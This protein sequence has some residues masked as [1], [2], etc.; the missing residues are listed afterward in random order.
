MRMPDLR[1]ATLL[2]LTNLLWGA[3]PPPSNW[4]P[5][6]W[7]WADAQSLELLEGSPVNCVLLKAYNPDL[8]GAA[9]K[10]GLVVLAVVP[11][12]ADPA[13]AVRR[14]LA[15]GVTGI[16]ME[17]NFSESVIAS[18]RR[19]AGSA[20]VVELRARNHLPLGSSLSILGTYQGVW[21]GIAIEENGAK[22][23]GPTGTIWIDTNGGFLRGMRASGDAAPWIANQPPPHTIVTSERYMQVIADA[24]I[25]GARW[26]LS[27]DEDFAGRLYRR[28]PAALRD[29]RRITEMIRFFESHPEWRQ[30]GEYGKVA[31]VESPL[32]SGLISGGVLDMMAANHMPARPI[33]PENLSAQAIRGAAFVVNLESGRLTAG[34]EKILHDFAGAGGKLM[35]SPPLGTD[36]GPSGERIT[37][38]T[39]EFDRLDRLWNELNSEF[40]RRGYGVNVFNAP[41][42][43]SNVLASTGE[44]ALV[45][46]LVNY[47]DYPVEAVTAR[48]PPEYRRATLFRPE[49]GS[50]A[51]EIVRTD[52][53]ASVTLDRVS[54]CATIQL[55][56]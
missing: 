17:G 8:V 32:G 47:S 40:P 9:T 16:V 48:F 6:R 36:A 49:G 4:T 3:V 44:K 19:A 37:L 23:A 29:W 26:V 54:V 14:A 34:Q 52:A 39:A 56:Q 41:S 13:A 51:L 5:M 27:L 33:A 20:P 31:V 45:V 42:M 7:P 28:Q 18:A 53:G 55:E 11:T 30:M 43:I 38:D 35:T 15:A 25:A 46:H 2:S 12:G 50:Q 24:G 21:P 10:R 1:W 22:K